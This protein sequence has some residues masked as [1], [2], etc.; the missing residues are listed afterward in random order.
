MA[1]KCLYCGKPLENPKNKYCSKV[2][3]GKATGGYHGRE[4]DYDVSFPWKK[5]NDR[6]YE[7]RYNEG[8]A[9]DS[10]HCST[11]GWNPVVAA[12]RKKEAMA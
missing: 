7:C 9:C 4:A 10:R 3:A 6:F 12:A 2:C 11:C 8:C 5:L 1:E